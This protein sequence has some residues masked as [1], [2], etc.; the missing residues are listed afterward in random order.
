MNLKVLIQMAALSTRNH[1][2]MCSLV[3]ALPAVVLKLGRNEL[4][5]RVANDKNHQVTKEE[6]S[7]LLKENSTY[8]GSGSQVF[9]TPPSLEC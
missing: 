8:L 7:K 1:S 6:I 3:L 9:R 2:T 5:L 4:I